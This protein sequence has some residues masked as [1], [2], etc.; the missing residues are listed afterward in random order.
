VSRDLVSRV[1]EAVVEDMQAWQSRPFDAA[2]SDHADRRDRAQ[3]P[4]SGAPSVMVVG[5]G[6][7]DPLA[8]QVEVGT[9]RHLSFEGLDPVDVA[10]D[11]S[12]SVAQ[13]QAVADGQV[14]A[15][16]VA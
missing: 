10:F 12:G 9:A 5:S 6:D 11:G 7:Q 4:G 13:R 8:Q 3:F 16:G 14:V 2:Q 15:A 1:T